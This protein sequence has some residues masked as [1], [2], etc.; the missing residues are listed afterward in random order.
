MS[1]SASGGA[2]AG[3]LSTGLMVAIA[4]IVAVALVAVAATVVV[5]TSSGGPTGTVKD[6][7]KSITTR[8]AGSAF[9]DTVLSLNKS[10]YPLFKHFEEFGSD[11]NVSIVIHNLTEV[12]K[13]Q[14]TVGQRDDMNETSHI[15]EKLFNVTVQDYCFVKFNVT[16]KV[17]EHDENETHNSSGKFSLVKV[18]GAWLIVLEL[19]DL[20]D[21]AQPSATRA[22]VEVSS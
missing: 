4:V 17:T 9:N 5:V 11:E 15:V 22:A 1:A 3:G 2:A 8:D 12:S 21:L 18:N 16:F 20:E 13:S 19:E 7:L 10:L 14:M 6:Y